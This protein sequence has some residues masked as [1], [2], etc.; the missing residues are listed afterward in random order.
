[1]S[2]R[3]LRPSRWLTPPSCLGLERLEDRRMLAD[4]D[5]GDTLA[6]A[7]L[8]GPLGTIPLEAIDAIRSASGINRDVD[9]F[10]FGA[11]RGQHVTIECRPP[12]GTDGFGGVPILRLFNTDGDD[13]V[14]SAAGQDAAPGTEVVPGTDV[15]DPRIIAFSV[16]SAGRYFIGVSSEQNRQYDPR[17]A[18]DRARVSRG[19]EYLLTVTDSEAVNGRI[20]HESAVF[21]RSVTLT[22]PA[23]LDAAILATGGSTLQPMI[24]LQNQ[25]GSLVATARATATPGAEARVQQIVTPGTYVIAVTSANGSWGNF[26]GRLSISPRI[27]PADGLRS[28]PDNPANNPRACVADDVDGDGI[29]DIVVAAAGGGVPLVV[30]SQTPRRTFLSV[31][32]GTADGAFL[33][34]FVL[35]FAGANTPGTATA[36]AV[37]RDGSGR[38]EGTAWRTIA[39]TA[40]RARVEADA[41]VS[42]E[43]T[44]TLVSV[45]GPQVRSSVTPVF[46]GL[47]PANW[48][49]AEAPKAALAALANGLEAVEL[50]VASG[51][52]A[53]VYN[54]ST[55][56][57]IPRRSF[58]FALAD[59]NAAISAI[60]YADVDNDS[61]PDLLLV[62]ETNHQVLVHRRDDSGR[63]EPTPRQKI[64]V[65]SGPT[66]IACLD[67]DQDGRAEIVT[68]DLLDI[69]RATAGVGQVSVCWNHP[70][71]FDVTNLD[72]GGGPMA[73]AL[74]DVN[75]DRRPDIVT[76]NRYT[77]DVSVLLNVADGSLRSMPT[78]YAGL[79]CGD[80]AAADV[81]RD[82]APDLVVIDHLP[83]LFVAVEGLPAQPVAYPE[84]RVA[85]I[86]VLFGRGDGTFISPY[87]RTV[88]GAVPTAVAAGDVNGDGRTDIAVA[89]FDSSDISVLLGNGDGTF[90]AGARV[91][92]P[93]VGTV[94]R[95]HPVKIAL[96]DMNG[97]GREDLAVACV[98]PDLPADSARSSRLLVYRGLG[99]GVFESFPARDIPLPGDPQAVVA[100]EFVGDGTVSIVTAES[101]DP[102]GGQLSIVTGLGDSLVR[103]HLF[104]GRLPTAVA[105]GTLGDRAV[106]VVTT[107]ASDRPEQSDGRVVILEN[108]ASSPSGFRESTLTGSIGVMPRAVRLTDIDGDGY[109]DIVT[110]AQQS[111]RITIFWGGEASSFSPPQ[112][113]DI[114]GAPV[115]VDTLTID[116]R[117]ALVTAN[118]DTSDIAFVLS[119]PSAPRHFLTPQRTVVYD[120]ASAATTGDFN[121]DGRLDLAV[122]DGRNG[123]SLVLAGPSGVFSVFGSSVSNTPAAPVERIDLNGT[124]PI[125]LMTI[126]RGGKLTVRYDGAA[127]TH[128]LRFGAAPGPVAAGDSAV[129]APVFD[130]I[131]LVTRSASDQVVAI[132]YQR[133]TLLV[134][135]PSADG[136]VIV[137][138]TLRARPPRTNDPAGTVLS[139]LG[140][141]EGVSGDLNGDGIADIV[142]SNPG[143]G[144]IDILPSHS[145]GSFD[146]ARWESFDAGTGPTT[147]LLADIDGDGVADLIAA[148]QVS[149]DVSVRLGVAGVLGTQAFR[150]AT[151][152]G[153]EFRYRTSS[154]VYGYGIDPFSG[155]GSAIAPQKLSDIALGDV[156]G[157]GLV[158]L[159][160]TSTQDRSFSIL[161]GVPGADGHWAGFG[162]PE[163]HSAL[164]PIPLGTAPA[165]LV[166]TE[167]AAVRDVTVA[168]LDDDGRADIALLDPVGERV[169]LYTSRRT[170]EFL[171]AASLIALTGVI[172]KSLQTADLTGPRGTPDGI[173]DL[174]VGNDF[175]DVFTL[176]GTGDGGFEP[177]RSSAF[178]SI[179]ADRSVA[180][181]ATD[182][183]GDGREDFIYGNKGLDTVVVASGG[184]WEMFAADRRQGLVAPSGVAT[185][186][187]TV[188]GRSVKNLVVTNGGGN[189]IL[190]FRNAAGAAGTAVGFLPPEAFFV[191]TNPSAL[192]TGDVNGD[193]IPDVVVA[194]E[195]SDDISVLLGITGAD[196]RWTLSPGL[197]LSTGGKSPAGVAIGDFVT[198]AG[199]SGH[200]GISDIAVTNR[201][202]NSAFM[203]PGLSGGF[204]NDRSPIPLPLPPNAGPG[205]IVPTPRGPAIG[206][207]NGS[208][209]VVTAAASGRADA[210]FV[211]RTYATG[212]SGAVSLAVTVRGG[213]TFL[214][215]GTAGS[216][217]VSQ[218]LARPGAL[219]FTF[220]RSAKLLDV[221]GL[222]YTDRGLF[223]TSPTQSALELFAFDGRSR[224]RDAD[225][226]QTSALR[227]AALFVTVRFSAVA[228][229]AAIASLR[230][231]ATATEAADAELAAKQ[232]AADSEPAAEGA[233]GAAADPEEADGEAAPTAP[234]AGGTTIDEAVAA[235]GLLERFF[236]GWIDAE[237]RLAAS[238]ADLLRAVA[239]A[240]Q[241]PKRG[242][243]PAGDPGQASGA[244]ASPAAP[245]AGGPPT[246]TGAAAHGPAVEPGGGE[247]AA[248]PADG[249]RPDS[250]APVPAPTGDGA[251]GVMVVVTTA[252]GRGRRGHRWH[253]PNRH[254]AR[255]D[256]LRRRTAR[257]RPG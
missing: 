207:N 223:G 177:P 176:Q 77:N 84:R 184:T 197:R 165:P 28:D 251:S 186:D 113:I 167:S 49:T 250:A 169:L 245:A 151:G 24:R 9:I 97:D 21:L 171:P 205:P 206:N 41:S 25:S 204:F 136:T 56:D 13:L 92:V 213:I 191:G 70:D 89:N 233:D 200:D 211:S 210:A 76:A 156:N 29:T 187:E 45:A 166:P 62:D 82:G 66:A 240:D 48:T 139:R 132:G 74:V 249:G 118:H 14:F 16:P 64:S 123:V 125:D 52:Q 35:S 19:F 122:S 67:L 221:T 68:A 100:S 75:N 242:E 174:V 154:R 107:V 226:T 119:D 170:P 7:T 173:L 37:L 33:P 241:R 44:L 103:R 237:E 117:T 99:T 55:G 222:A 148:N 105:S 190:L 152:F 50:A 90:T 109:T 40:V 79:A 116:G 144:S 57:S 96:A 172:P 203:I 30:D 12:V 32:R 138:Q 98:L 182:V 47:A 168:D 61:R 188:G 115:S 214:S 185:V 225:A 141:A 194:N 46:Q 247:Q 133:A 131:P 145:D 135:A 108:D 183:D 80:L 27:N 101:G 244:P 149:G 23:L 26:T 143:A 243:R 236:G 93:V 140:R 106:F 59:T 42:L 228:L 121:G 18:T 224:G 2:R 11:T 192:A 179:R 88:T 10:A 20:S 60:T 235:S 120:G 83:P 4:P 215:A 102:S 175:G 58:S 104:P 81:D 3:S 8:L 195:G 254:R 230:L 134:G 127:S 87:E 257:P 31:F 63:I 198:Q 94:G 39:V 181:V 150:A 155:R 178:A 17:T 234:G 232:A 124:A 162:P 246:G 193:G 248:P 130:A 208:F 161:L 36:V 110:I 227:G 218:F 53:A 73:V 22:Q 114:E 128:G 1:M 142:V 217:S 5:A 146:D 71:H 196:G 85:D 38:V 209:T 252:H 126:D 160:A 6:S 78:S 137:S 164:A 239:A 199:R 72:V 220:D 219:D 91:S 238:A 86:G 111:N 65:G 34:P 231:P 229:V 253:G 158:D 112:Q 256:G 189:Q 201:G 180:L 159:V 15:N 43:T 147:V 153:P 202:S 69:R 255:P 54:L 95:M 163:R 51:D 216:G 129:A 157:D 212:G